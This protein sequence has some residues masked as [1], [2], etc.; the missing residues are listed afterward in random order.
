MEKGEGKGEEQVNTS[1]LHFCFPIS[2]GCQEAKSPTCTFLPPQSYLL[3]C[4]L[5]RHGLSALKLSARI[6]LSCH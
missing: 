3:P 4:F 6:S 1:L 5:H 2:P